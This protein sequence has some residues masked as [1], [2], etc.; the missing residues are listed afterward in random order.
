MNPCD[1]RLFCSVPSWKKAFSSLLGNDKLRVITLLTRAAPPSP[2]LGEYAYAYCHYRTWSG[3][4][5]L[6]RFRINN[7]ILSTVSNPSKLELFMIGLW[8]DFLGYI[9]LVSQSIELRRHVC[10]ST[11][12]IVPRLRLSRADDPS[13]VFKA[14]CKT[15]P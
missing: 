6:F 3:L 5:R 10:N 1:S 12:L 2:R 15:R 14:E 11:S 9:V 7:N 8:E 4:D 13:G